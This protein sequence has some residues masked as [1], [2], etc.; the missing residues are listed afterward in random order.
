MTVGIFITNRQEAY[1]IADS[2]VSA[3]GRESNSY[4]KIGI[5]EADQ[6][7]GVIF[8][9]G[10]ANIFDSI[11]KN[12]DQF[13]DKKTLDDYI[14]AIHNKLKEG[15]DK[16]DRQFIA[17]H[18]NDI[19]KKAEA[20]A[21]PEE[22]KQ[23]IQA[24]TQKLMQTYE[25]MK[26]NT[27]LFNIVAYDKDAKGVR[28]F[29]VSSYGHD[30]MFVDHTEIGSG[31]DGAH[32]YLATK[33]QGVNVEK[34]KSADL[35]FFLINAYS[36]ANVNS[37]VGGTPKIGKIY[38]EEIKTLSQEGTKLVTNI[39]GAYLAELISL[40]KAREVCEMVDSEKEGSVVVEGLDVDPS[41]LTDILIP[42]SHWQ[43]RA[44]KKFFNHSKNIE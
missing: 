20:I 39:S 11:V 24:E 10:S 38:S 8:G 9:A 12:L 28:A 14:A 31:T 7:H 43:E 16:F 37:G 35:L 3:S 36:Y 30:E 18:E 19:Q 34:L 21:D 26:G 42:F 1:A 23:Y 15:A 4:E 22:R 25:N 29:S 41:M 33:L 6:Y 17:S 13:K 27:S 5:V 44:N 32:F 2:Q 40:Q